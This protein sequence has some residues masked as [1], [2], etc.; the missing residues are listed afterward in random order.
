MPLTR[1]KR[2]EVRSDGP[3]TEA[4]LQQKIEAYG[5]EVAA[6][7]YPAGLASAAP[8]EARETL[9]AVVR[10]LVKLTIDGEP[11]I[12]SAG[13]MAFIPGG[14]LRRV[15]VVGPSTALCLEAYRR[16]ETAGHA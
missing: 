9:I 12:L 11:E 4:A 16:R 10:G 7:T 2:W 13:D 8:P 5:F 15:E 1:I 14:I 6:R 3:L